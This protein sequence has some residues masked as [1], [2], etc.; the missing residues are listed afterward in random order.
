MSTLDSAV[1]V[2]V[3]ADLDAPDRIL[4]GL[5]TRQVAILA[6]TATVLWLAFQALTPAVPAAVVGIAAVPVGAVATVVALGRRDG[7]SMDRWLAAA[8]P[9]P[10]ARAG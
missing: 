4:Y 10:A 7:I 1:Q 8:W 2:H 9:R 5:T 6:G 3:P